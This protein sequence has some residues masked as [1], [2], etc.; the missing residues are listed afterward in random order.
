MSTP[1]KPVKGLSLS[2]PRCAEVLEALP[3]LAP[4]HSA[5]RTVLSYADLRRA[6]RECAPD[7]AVVTNIGFLLALRR[8]SDHRDEFATA[9]LQGLCAHPDTWALPSDDAIAEK[10]YE[11][12]GAMLRAREA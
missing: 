5:V 12:A 2:D 11:L 7:K 3:G 10:A 4:A 8:G 1:P 6:E 9:A